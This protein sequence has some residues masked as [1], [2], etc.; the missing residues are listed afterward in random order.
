M[1]TH[2]KERFFLVAII[3]PIERFLGSEV[4]CV[5]LKAFLAAIHLNEDGVVVAAL[6]G[7]NLPVVEANGIGFQMPFADD[8]GVIAALLQCLGDRP[9]ARIEV[10]AVAHKAVFVAVFAGENRCSRR[11]TNRIG[12]K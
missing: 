2:Q 11:T 5:S 1:L 12:A 7:K 6:P 4:G 8:R 9:L 3:Q 10:V